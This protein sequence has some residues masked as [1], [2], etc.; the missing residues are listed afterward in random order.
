M[1]IIWS[2]LVFMFFYLINFSVWRYLLINFHILSIF[3]FCIYNLV[4]VILVV[5]YYFYLAHYNDMLTLSCQILWY[6]YGPMIL[7]IL[8][9]FSRQ[10]GVCVVFGLIVFCVTQSF[11]INSFLMVIEL[12]LIFYQFFLFSFQDLF[13]SFLV[14][15]FC[16][17]LVLL[18]LMLCLGLT[19]SSALSWSYVF[20]CFVLVLLILM[21]C[22]GLTYSYCYLGVQEERYCVSYHKVRICSFI[23]HWERSL[24]LH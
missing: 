12:V 17:V 19:Y 24:Y 11:L 21:L 5:Y 23:R 16:F 3:S 7:S 2:I 4:S 13:R 1:L 6:L 15:F 14:L 10:I 8:L 18:I 20:L 22:L 9:V